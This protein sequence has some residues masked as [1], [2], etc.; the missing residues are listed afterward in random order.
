MSAERVI[1]IARGE[2]SYTENPAGSNRTKYGAAYGLQ[3]QPWC[4]IFL[5]WC[6]REAGEAAAFFGGGKTASCGTLLRWY[7][8]QGQTV[9]VSKAR[10][11]DIVLLNFHNGQ[12]PEHC[13][14]VVGTST[15]AYIQTIEG[16]TSPGL[17]GSQ[18]NGGCV[19][20]KWR[21]ARQ[22]VAVLR[23]NYK[24]EQ[25]EKQKDYEGHWAEKYIRWCIEHGLMMGY[26]DGSFGPDKPVTRAELATVLR[27]L[28]DR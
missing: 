24:E 16:N 27:R 19:A 1:E 10:P 26:E 28:E 13:G 9:P 21:Y 8:A 6:F 3:N 18:D 5:W 20:L 23:P 25:V 12:E 17:E 11:G 7:A 15:N 2:L 14:L 22:V 4:V